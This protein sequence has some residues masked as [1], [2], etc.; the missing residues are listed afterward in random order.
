MLLFLLHTVKTLLLLQSQLLLGQAEAFF[1]LL[2]L[3]S[4]DLLHLLSL[5]LLHEFHLFP[6]AMHLTD[7]V[8]S[9]VLLLAVVRLWC[10]RWRFGLH[11]WGIFHL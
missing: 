2:D 3:R 9:I 10:V 5:L 4:P 11:W 8:K 1:F 7:L 6:Q